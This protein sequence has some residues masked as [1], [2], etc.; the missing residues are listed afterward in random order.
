MDDLQQTLID[1]RRGN[2]LAWEAL[3]KQ[4]QGRVYSVAYHYLGNKADAEDATQ[5]TFIKVYRRLKSFR[6]KR[7]AFL[8]WLLAIARNCCI[9]RLRRQKTRR[10]Y[11]DGAAREA[12]RSLED[13]GGNAGERTEGSAMTTDAGPI[14]ATTRE[15]E[16]EL[17]RAQRREFLEQALAQF[18]AES[19][20]VVLLKDIQGLKNE[21][22]ANI[23]ALPLGT[24][25]SRSNRARLKLARLWMS[26]TA[27][28]S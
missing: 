13:S 28:E 8:P 14:G 6:S 3:V 4:F 1:C 21:E 23:L 20:D 16:Q 10:K 26:L 12:E 25:K 2:A 11:E 7:Q 18:D 27:G 15:P 22:V 17:V 24:V 5:E 19:R 9:D